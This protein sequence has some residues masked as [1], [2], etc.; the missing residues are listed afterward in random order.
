[1]FLMRNIM[2]P[3]FVITSGV[4]YQLVK[5]SKHRFRFRLYLIYLYYLKVSEVFHIGNDHV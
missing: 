5:L 4:Y 3:T 1:M 2:K